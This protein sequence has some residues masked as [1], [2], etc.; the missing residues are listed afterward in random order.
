MIYSKL[1]L[2]LHLF[3][4]FT[5]T[6]VE[7]YIGISW[8]RMARQ[9]MIPSMVVDM[10]LQNGVPEVKLYT[11]SRN[12]LEAFAGTNIG[13]TITMPNDDLGTITGKYEIKCPGDNSL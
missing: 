1:L 11:T 7:S 5:T 10:L 9:R 3:L 6:L 12:V 13:V 4:I 2:C 8:G